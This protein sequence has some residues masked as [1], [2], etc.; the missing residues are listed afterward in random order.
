MRELRRK[1]QSM[2]IWMIKC[3][4]LQLSDGWKITFIMVDG[5]ISVI[6]NKT[7]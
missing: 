1:K 7:S 5:F 4:L 3:L 2:L 6:E